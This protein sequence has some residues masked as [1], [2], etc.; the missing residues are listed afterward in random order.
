MSRAK[1]LILNTFIL[2]FGTILPKL[3]TFVIL[4]IITMMLTKREYGTY[5]LIITGASLLLPLF[6]LF[7]VSM[8]SW[9]RFDRI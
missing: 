2:S 1:R 8:K 5:D 6:S 3:S 4:P 9:T 7:D